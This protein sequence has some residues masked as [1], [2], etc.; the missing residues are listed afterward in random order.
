MQTIL[1]VGGGSIG[2]IA[3]AIAVWNAYHQKHPQ[4]KAHFVCSTRP[5]D[6]AFLQKQNV[7]FTISNAPRLSLAYP[8]QFIR[9]MR[10]AKRILV[11][12][13][14]DCIFSK[15]G[16]VS[17]PLCAAAKK[18][19]IPIILHESDAISGYANRI[20][21]RW[22]QSVCTG[23]PSTHTFTGNPVR[24]AITKGIKKEG[25]RLT[26]F[27]GKKPIILVIGGSQGATALNSAIMHHADDLLLRADII[28]I[29]GRGKS[30]I[31]SLKPQASRHYYQTE[32][33]NKELKHFYACSDIAI[34]RAG[35]GSIAE[36]A[37]NGIA[38]ILVPL[39][40]VGHDHQYYNAQKAA[41]TGGCIYLEQT[42]LDTKLVPTIHNL[43]ADKS[44]RTEMS[45][46]IR[47]LSHPDAALHI[48]DIIAQTL[49]KA[50]SHQ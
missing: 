26:G 50:R 49:A 45:K 9:A 27:D 39:R 17:I 4:S 29:T 8:L 12:Q 32:F 15:G 10:E 44:L 23:F 20:V 11:T 7:A 36:L 48:A 24:D 28:H 18:M 30:L 1:F 40:G 22:A 33:A 37:A 25:L 14:P 41:E 31:S 46:K 13:K 6:G 19:G 5:D 38:T 42:Q 21:S 34:S 47:T 16:Y 3:P 2:H 35:A 43:V